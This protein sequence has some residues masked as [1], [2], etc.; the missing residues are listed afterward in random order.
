MACSRLGRCLL[1]AGCTLTALGIVGCTPPQTEV[2]GTIKL[3]GKAPNVKGLEITFW[4]QDGKPTSAEIEPD[5]KYKAEKV[6][7]GEAR[8]AFAYLPPELAANKG[9]PRMVKPGAGGEAPKPTL[10][11]SKDPIPESLRD[12]LTSKITTRI[13][14]GKPNV[15]DYDIP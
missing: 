12:P 15:F 3:H 4:G 6:T 2:S 14:A 13:E 1:V 11:K 10:P 5:G 9:K 8:V 7:V